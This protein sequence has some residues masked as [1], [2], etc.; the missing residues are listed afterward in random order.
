MFLLFFF[1]SVSSCSLPS[2]LRLRLEITRRWMVTL[3]LLGVWSWWLQRWHLTLPQSRHPQFSMSSQTMID[4][5]EEEEKEEEECTVVRPIAAECR[6]AIK[7]VNTFFF[8]PV[9]FL[10]LSVRRR[11]I[12]SMIF[13][14]SKCHEL[15][16]LI[17]RHKVS[18]KSFKTLNKTRHCLNVCTHAVVLAVTARKVAP[19]TNL[20][21]LIRTHSFPFPWGHGVLTEF[22]W[23]GRLSTLPH[24]TLANNWHKNLHRFFF[25]FQLISKP[26]FIY[27]HCQGCSEVRL[28]IFESKYNQSVTNCQSSGKPISFRRRNWG[29]IIFSYHTNR[30]GFH[31]LLKCQTTTYTLASPGKG[32]SEHDQSD[33]TFCC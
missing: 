22:H 10:R 6:L 17:N 32:H 24:T 29:D 26:L 13:V 8:M 16:S 14:C 28:V 33:T 11:S 12:S 19:W 7:P 31:L 27:E 1:L 2:L 23:T 3:K 25:F 15:V 20:I 21:S 9:K 18:K 5:E 4:C 30:V